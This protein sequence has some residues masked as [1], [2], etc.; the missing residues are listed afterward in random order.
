MMMELIKQTDEENKVYHYIFLFNIKLYLT[1][2]F[3]DKFMAI[4]LSL[5]SPIG[6]M[7]NLHQLTT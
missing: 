5:A 6:F 1:P 3:H 4:V 7:Q 2:V